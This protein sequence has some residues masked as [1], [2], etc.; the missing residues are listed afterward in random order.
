[1]IKNFCTILILLSGLLFLIPC[2]GHAEGDIYVINAGK[3]YKRTVLVSPVAGDTSASGTALIQSLNAIT[4]ASATNPYLIKLEPGVY[5]LGSNHLSLKEYVDIEGSG[6]TATTIT[7]LGS[8][9]EDTGTV[10][11]CDNTEL[12]FLTIANTGGAKYATAVFNTKASTRLT[13]MTAEASGAT[14]GEAGTAINRAIYNKESASIITDVCAHVSGT[15][16]TS[17]L[18][19]AIDNLVSDAMIIDTKV[20]A[21]GSA[22]EFSIG[23]RNRDCS[24]SL[25]SCII[26]I[27]SNATNDVGIYNLSSSDTLETSPVINNSMVTASSNT[28]EGYAIMNGESGATGIVG[29]T[30][31][32]NNC[33]INGKTQSVFN[34]SP[35]IFLVSNSLLNGTIINNPGA[36]ATCAGVYDKDFVFYPGTCPIYVSP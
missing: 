1:M 19:C 28:A 29:G 30:V 26:M 33:N 14:A 9:T 35:F 10:L 27:S 8:D 23:V 20:T 32:V 6:E 36:T 25:R 3:R 31:K 22:F 12:R 11:G 15:L 18:N 21:T 13:S 5:D 17:P 7:A 34:N 16:Y 24:P 4:D 2:A